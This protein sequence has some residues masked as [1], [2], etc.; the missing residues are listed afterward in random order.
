MTFVPGQPLNLN[1]FGTK[2][3]GLPRG[4]VA[5]ASLL[6]LVG[7]TVWSVRGGRTMVFSMVFITSFHS[8][9]STLFSTVFSQILAKRVR[10]EVRS[11]SERGP[12]W[13]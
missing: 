11:R 3:S 12:S 13:P 5:Q 7:L 10:L 9:F 1:A 4:K 8:S 6:T 2:L